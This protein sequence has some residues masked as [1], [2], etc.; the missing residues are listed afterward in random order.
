MTKA[1]TITVTENAQGV[2][3]ATTK[4]FEIIDGVTSLI[5]TNTAITG[6]PA[7]LQKAALVAGGM[8]LNSKLKTGSFNFMK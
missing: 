3:T 6:M 5:S 4:D 8:S 1:Q 2:V 7:L